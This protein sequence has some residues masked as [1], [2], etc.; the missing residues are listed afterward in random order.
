MSRA[1]TETVYR[2]RAA[3]IGLRLEKSR[4]RTP[5]HPS[6]GG[7]MIV[8]IKRNFAV[9][10]ADHFAYSLSWEDLDTFLGSGFD[11]FMPGR[12]RDGSWRI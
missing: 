4:C 6:F 12:A 10:G 3:S 1:A 2:R 8:D 7:Y 11:D 9:A 5:E